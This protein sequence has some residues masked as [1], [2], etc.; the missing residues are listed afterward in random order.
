MTNYFYVSPEQLIKDR[1]EFAQK[2]IARGRSLVAAIYDKGVVMVA[3]NPSASLNKISEVYDRIAFA[4]VGRY[5]EFDRLREAGI[6]WAD[7]TGFTYSR[8]DVD[9][10]ALA[11]YYAQHLGDM[12][13]EGQKPLEVE[14][15]VAQLG[16]AL[17]P[18]KLYRVAYEGTISD[19]PYFAVV[20]GDAETIR[21]RFALSEESLETLAA[22]LK[23]AAA[24]L[25]GPDRVLPAEELEVCILED[26]GNR[27][28][29]LRLTDEQIKEMLS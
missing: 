11:N 14:I 21:D 16:N 7:T 12:F 15:L 27:R 20:G 22:T 17:R 9:A 5:N 8:D 26:R 19:E 18:T 29:F 10:R 25:A 28:T 2:G 6:R 24:A 13:T 1:A 4:G 3:E 23:N